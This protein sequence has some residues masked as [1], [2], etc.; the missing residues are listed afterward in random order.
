MLTLFQKLIKEL[1]ADLPL[2]PHPYQEIAR[3]VG[4]SEAQILSMIN[5]QIKQQVIRRLGAVLGHQKIGFK[6][7]G[8]GV[9]IVP[10][11][12]TDRVGEIMAAYPEVSHCYLRPS[13]ETWPYNLYTMIHGKSRRMCEQIAASI[14]LETGIK[15]Y[16][17]LFSV[18]ELK[19]QSMIYY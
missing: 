13:S 16:R 14:S 6:A 4:T 8:M 10:E 19:K 3:R 2:C 15:N 9:W 5:Q 18:K 12:D 11:T 7:N 1:Q 17:L